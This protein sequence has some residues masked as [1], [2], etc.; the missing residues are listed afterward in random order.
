MMQTLQCL[1]RFLVAPPPS[2]L[3][4]PLARLQPILAR[5]GK[6]SVDIDK[7]RQV[8]DGIAAVEEI[9]AVQSPEHW[10]ELIRT[11]GDDLD[12]VLLLSNPAYPTEIWNSHPQPL[13][14]RGLPV[15][16]WSLIDYDEPDFWRWA[17]RDMLQTIGVKVYLVKN[18][19]EG[20]GL[21]KALAMKRFLS[22]GKMVV[23]GEQNFP[24]NVYA[25][26]SRVSQNLRTQIVVR[27][28]D[29]VRSLYPGFTQK[30]VEQV[31]ATRLVGRYQQQAVR[32]EELDQAIR[33]YLAIRKILQDERAMAFGV[34]CFGDLIT[35]GGRDVPC[36]AQLLLRE[37]GFAT[38]CDGD[39]IAMLGMVVAN[40]FLDRPCMMSNLYPVSYVGALTDHFGDPLSPGASYPGNHQNLGRLAHCGFVG[41]IS[42]EMTPSGRVALHDWGGTYEIKRDGRGCGV[43]GDLVANEPA[44]V[45]SSDFEVK[46]L[47]VASARI[48]ET[49]RH[50]GLLHCEA[51]GLLEFRNLVGFEQ[52][53]SRDH[54]V[55]I[56]GDYA[57]D[58]EILAE[59][60]GLQYLLF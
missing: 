32:L 53:V 20:I 33:I 19:R 22:Q 4:R 54:V 13:V 59:V 1:T 8:L 51:S 31:L 11:L 47:A 29:D 30:E 40:F 9:Q 36:L 50:P 58:L 3:S 28:L 43:D 26:G 39:F 21:V 46:K 37:E 25:V 49:T 7:L 15:I 18:N 45:I 2:Y 35:R 56:Y 6:P 48:A 12:A 24:W 41:V 55:V 5:P 34:N 16:F 17:A 10:T 14:E 52:A 44:T 27:S 57:R 38:A 23:F 42:P 60:L